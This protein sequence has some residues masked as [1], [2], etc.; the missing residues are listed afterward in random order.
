MSR[1]VATKKNGDRCRAWAMVWGGGRYCFFHHPA[2]HYAAKR[3]RASSKGGRAT[4]EDMEWNAERRE[5]RA[6]MVALLDAEPRL[7]EVRRRAGL[8]E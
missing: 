3:K 8:W 7:A 2:P 6:S 1:C 5:T 4:L